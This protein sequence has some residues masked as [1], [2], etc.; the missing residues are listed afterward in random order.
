M[1]IEV[2]HVDAVDEHLTLLHVV[3]SRNEVYHGRL[4]SSALS[5][6]GYRLSF[7]YREVDVSEHP[8]LAVSERHMA[9]FYG[10]VEAGDVLRVLL[11]LDV[12]FGKQDLV[13]TLH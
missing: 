8:L 2:F 13:Y 10:V 4:S 11:L 7:L 6:E 5:H 3:V 1:D 12:A 9:E